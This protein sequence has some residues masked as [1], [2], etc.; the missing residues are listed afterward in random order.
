[1][2]RSTSLMCSSVIK[3]AKYSRASRARERAVGGISVMTDIFIR[4]TFRAAT[5]AII[6]PDIYYIAWDILNMKFIISTGKKGSVEGERGEETS[7]ICASNI[8]RISRIISN[9]T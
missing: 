5:G 4:R 8:V 3:H 9:E 1:M 7:N 6:L 2:Y